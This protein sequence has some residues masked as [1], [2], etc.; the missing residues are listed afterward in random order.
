MVFEPGPPTPAPPT[1][2]TEKAKAVEIPGPWK[3][4]LRW[5]QGRTIE[6]Q[7]PKLTDLSTNGNPSL[8]EFS[9]VAVYR[10]AFTPPRDSGVELDLG[11]VHGV[12]EVTLNGQ[13]L[14]TRWWGKHVYE[15]GRALR[16]GLNVLEVKVTTTLFNALGSRDMKKGT[17]LMPKGIGFLP[18]GLVGPV[19]LR[20]PLAPRTP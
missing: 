8:Q 17:A 11:A 1:P 2:A 6:L 7:M 12:S 3:V 20:G 9:G 14:G 10:I 13:K 15:V 16:P 18:S 4:S 5:P 19:C